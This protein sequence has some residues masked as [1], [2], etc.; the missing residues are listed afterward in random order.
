M[1][2]ILR[3]VAGLSLVA[4][5]AGRTAGAA[6]DTFPDTWVATDALGRVVPTHAEVG[7][8]RTDRTLG[9]FYF[10]WHGAHIQG[11]PYDVT[12]IL[13]QDPDAMSKPDSP[14]W[15]PLHAPH[16]WGESLFGYYLTQDEGVLRKHAQMLSDAG[17]DVVIFDVTN[18]ITYPEDYRA[19]LRVWSEV[20]AAGNPTPQVAFLTPFW[21]PARVVRQLWRDLYQPGLFR[22]LWFRWEGRPLILADPALLLER[23]GNDQQD[24]PVPLP[25]GQ[26]L[27]QTFTTDRP[28]EGVGGRFPTWNTSG[29]GMTLTLF[30]DGPTGELLHRQRAENVRDNEW[31]MLKLPA[32]LPPGTYYLE[33]SESQGR[34]G[35]WSHSADVLPGSTSFTNRQPGAGDR[36]LRLLTT[37]DESRALRDFFTFRKPQPD[38]FQGPTGPDQWS[39]LE[40][41]PQHVFTNAAG[42]KEQMAVGVAQNAVGRRLGAMSE[43]GARGRSFHRGATDPRPGAV[44][45]GL[46]FAEQWERA[47]A[48]DPRFVF[49][50]GWNEWIAGRFA[51]FNGVRLPVMFV[52][53]FDQ[54]HSRDLEP[55]RGGHGDD[56]Y[57]QFVGFVRRYKGAR[58]VPPITPSPIRVEGRFDDW[59]SVA[60][61][62]RDT[63]G[64]PVRRRHR[65]W[66]PAVTYENQTG[67]NDLEAAKVSF[68]ATHLWLYV[69]C[70][71]A[72]TPATDT[73]W[74]TAWLDVDG[75]AT[76][77]W[78]G[79]DF[80]LNAKRPEPNRATTERWSGA[81]WTTVA[82]VEF[83]SAGNELE[84]EVPWERLGFTEPPRQ[85]DF[86]WT[87]N[88]ESAGDWTDFTLNG[89]A[90]PNDRFNYRARLRP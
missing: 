85:F 7:P 43:P 24:S 21:D 73:N 26:T 25:P 20:R 14:L 63:L 54:E 19:L 17:V 78:L 28:F 38:Y 89:D 71:E 90:A 67:R 86:K 51:E 16:H 1:K 72:L 34:I 31:R 5:F 80:R 84:I 74:M 4:A 75:N 64:D 68:S 32:P 58:P 50:T 18:Q 12:Q 13:A 46:N 22:D 69:R 23:T 11:G 8:P 49:V 87:D 15:G 56:Y 82:T 57:Y 70:R 65:G 6:W 55:M 81:G 52:D 33:A 9:L 36:T 10:L 77:G 2:I 76:N 88:C 27:G 53:Q 3:V 61:E 66:D 60:P 29:A 48:E 83:R 37:D 59:Q 40:I 39:W 79:Y 45:W 42:L 35:W 62:F 47:L 41:H 44:R 30:R